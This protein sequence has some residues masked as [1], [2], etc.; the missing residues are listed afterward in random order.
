[1]SERVEYVR[2]CDGV[3]GFHGERDLCTKSVSL[4]YDP[5]RA[6]Y[7]VLHRQPLAGTRTVSVSVGSQTPHAS[8]VSALP[9]V[10]GARD[11]STRILLGKPSRS[12]SQALGIEGSTTMMLMG[13]LSKYL[14]EWTWINGPLT[15]FPPK[16]TLLMLVDW[17]FHW[18]LS[19]SLSRP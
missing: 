19:G 6:R 15:W 10:L 1:M 17:K 4:C 9:D 8:E 7:A 5:S 18:G 12:M 14:W 16:H 13:L 11:G 3:M 2:T